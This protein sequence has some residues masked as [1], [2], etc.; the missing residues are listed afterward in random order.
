[1]QRGGDHT[2]G[3]DVHICPPPHL[4][5]CALTCPC[6]ALGPW[7]KI[8]ND[9]VI[10]GWS[11][12]QTHLPPQGRGEGVGSQVSSWEGPPFRCAPHPLLPGLQVKPR[13]RQVV[14]GVGRDLEPSL[15]HADT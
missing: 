3:Q 7:K 5:C 6:P 8:M 9:M 13:K 11:R 15:G 1:M 12:D 4:L 14:G 2:E 10:R